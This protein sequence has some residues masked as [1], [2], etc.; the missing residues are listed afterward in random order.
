VNED[1]KVHIFTGERKRIKKSQG[2]TILDARQD[3]EAQCQESRKRRYW[4]VSESIS[5]SVFKAKDMISEEHP[6]G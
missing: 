5:F 4:R 3:L 1:P 2:R 6:A